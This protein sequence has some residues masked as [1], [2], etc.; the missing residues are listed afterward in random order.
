MV[1]IPCPHHETGVIEGKAR[2][3]QHNRMDQVPATLSLEQSDSQV[4]ALFFP[5]FAGRAVPP[6]PVA[7]FAGRPYGLRF[8]CFNTM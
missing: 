2:M 8:L 7:D 4:G 3:L 1:V 5:G 6:D